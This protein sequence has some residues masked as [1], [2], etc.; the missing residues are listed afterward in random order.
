M[1]LSKL[2]WKEL[3]ERPLSLATCLLAVALGVMAFVAIR[4][5]V[6]ASEAVVARDLDALGANVLML[7]RDSSLQDYYAADQHGRTLPEEYATQ[8]VLAGLPGVEHVSPKL[9][10]P[11]EVEGKS[12]V[13]TGILPQ[14]EFQAKAAWGGMQ[15]MGTPHVG[16][17]AAHV[18]E[19]P[20]T[21]EALAQSRVVQDLADDAVILGVDAGRS[22]GAKRGS[23]VE[24]LG[25]TFRVVAILPATGTIDD[26]RIFAHLHAVQRLAKSGEVVAAI[27]IMGC[28]ED[29]ASSLVPALEKMFPD[30]KIATISQV[31]AT[32]VSV[33]RTLSRLSMLVFAVLVVIGSASVASVMFANVF[34][35]R[36]E[37]GTLMALGAAPH[38]VARLFLGKGAL[39]GLVGGTIGAASGVALAM[40]VGPAWAGVNVQPLP[41]LACLAVAIAVGMAIVSSYFPARKA[42]GLDPCLCFREV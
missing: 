25:E 38:L 39:L 24:L 28:C 41:Q 35:R 6:V 21:P 42:A 1:T 8:I 26:S 32:Q 16:C 18:K 14:S 31:L 9:A 22:L 11:V 10:T 27:E 23:T 17:K 13:L 5:I 30:A 29:V 4:H 19:T 33:N 3:W 7:P 20:K 36:R 12:F 15:L 40:A 2:I 37:I 34:E